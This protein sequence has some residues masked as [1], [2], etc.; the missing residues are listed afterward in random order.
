MSLCI[1]S[2]SLDTE[3]LLSLS[4]SFVFDKHLHIQELSMVRTLFENVTHQ[5]NLIFIFSLLF[6]YMITK[7][8]IYQLNTDYNII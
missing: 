6:K 2:V 1:R 7:L 3:V 8:L 5:L 4:L